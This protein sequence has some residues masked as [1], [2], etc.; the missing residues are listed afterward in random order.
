MLTIESK[1]NKQIAKNLELE[2]LKVSKEQQKLILDAINSD[3]EINNELIR[4]IA[5]NNKCS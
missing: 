5:F 4:Q 2:G 3:K 1:I